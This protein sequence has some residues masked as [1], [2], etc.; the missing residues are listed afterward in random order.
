MFELFVSF[1]VIKRLKLIGMQLGLLIFFMMAYPFSEYL[2][3]EKLD[4]H[5]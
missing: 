1:M 4:S 3:T 5:R 2:S